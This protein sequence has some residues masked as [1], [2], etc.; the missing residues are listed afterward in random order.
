MARDLGVAAEEVLHGD[1]LLARIVNNLDGA[2]RGAA[3][4][5]FLTIAL[6]LSPA[7]R[8]T[9]ACMDAAAAVL[10]DYAAEVQAIQDE[11]RALDTAWGAHDDQVAA[12]ASALTRV[13]RAASAA[14]AV[15]SDQI[16]LRRL[17]DEG[18]ALAAESLRLGERWS[19]LEARRQRADR[20]AVA[21]LQSETAVGKARRFGLDA[22]SL[23]DTE[24]LSALG[25]LPPEQFAVL[26]RDDAFVARLARLPA[27]LVAEWWESL[28]GQ[29]VGGL[30]AGGSSAGGTSL[31]RG[32]AHAHS[33]VQAA[34]IAGL[35]TVIGNLNGV[36]YWARDRANRLV[37]RREYKRW[38]R[39]LAAAEAAKAS[40]ASGASRALDEARAQVAALKNFLAGAT[41]KL[42]VRRGTVRQMLV[43]RPGAPPLGAYSVGDLDTA[44]G[45]TFLVPGMGSSLADTTSYMRA[46]SNVA[47]RHPSDSALVAWLGYEAP[48]N[49]LTTGNPGVFGEQYAERGA[50]MLA[51]DL[52]GV[53]ATR[54]DATLNV[55]GHSYGSTTAALALA[56]APNLGVRTFVTLGSAGIPGRVPDAAATNVDQMYA[57]QAAEL[58]DVAWIGRKY[59]V[60]HRADPTDEFGATVIDT[61]DGERVDVHDL[62]VG[63]NRNN[64]HGYLDAGTNT[65]R[66]T[67]EATLP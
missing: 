17:Q 19:E 45:I 29:S 36:A 64:R 3:W 2:W 26:A 39:K 62:F 60:P 38:R 57:A 63:V 1:Q 34:L 43:F 52:E 24:F 4:D 59:S 22:T 30:S 28:G 53:R 23:S 31:G 21:G 10:T 20:R 42:N 15:E 16:V 32:S 66:T 27:G 51:G 48:P 47:A 65:L 37:A 55:I 49:I 12:H 9:A 18:S 40:G 8:R 50:R 56:D 58:G 13:E 25:K 14:T 54:P 41:T 33:A 44:N 67:A 5:Q 7:A 6:S 46:A 35:P 11:A 61:R